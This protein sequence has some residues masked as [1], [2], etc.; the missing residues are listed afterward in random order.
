MSAETASGGL[1]LPGM[2]IS[3]AELRSYVMRKSSW[4]SRG[5]LDAPAK[6]VSSRLSSLAFGTAT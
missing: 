3:E 5:V 4:D 1:I 6:T 2:F